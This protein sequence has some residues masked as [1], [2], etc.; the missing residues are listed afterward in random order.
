MPSSS[1]SLLCGLKF[2]A[3][4]TDQRAA[5]GQEGVVDVGVAFPA[6][7]E[8]AEVVQPGA[9]VRT[10]QRQWPSPEPCLVPRRAMTRFTPRHH[11][12]RR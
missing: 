7:A 11:S 9:K 12:A 2:R 5:E 1:D 4:P 8:P 3:A 6:D 10:T